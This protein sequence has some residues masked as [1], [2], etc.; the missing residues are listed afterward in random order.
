[1]KKVY[2]SLFLH[3]NMCYDRYTKQ[4]IRAKFPLIYAAGIRA[5]QRYPQVTA[6]IDFPGLTTLSLKHHAAWF[7]QELRS[8]VERGQVVMVG[9]QYAASHAMCSDE[10][11]DLQA[12]RLGMEIMRDELQP[13]VS[14]FFNQEIPFHPQEPYIM[15]QIGARRLLS[16]VDWGRPTWI[17][18]IDGSRLIICPLSSRRREGVG[19]LEGIY[20]LYEDGDL[21]LMGGDFEMLGNVGEMV[22]KIAELFARG[23]V[24]EWMTIDR[25]ERELGAGEE[26][27]APTPF[28][29]SPEDTP[30]SPSFSRWV[31]NPEDAIWHGHGVRAMDAIRTAGFAA[32]CARVHGLGAVDAPLSEAWTTEPDNAW[33]G[34]FEH[35]LEYPEVEARYLAW[36]RHPGQGDGH[37]TLLSRAWHHLLIGLNSDASGWKPWQPRTRHRETVLRASEALSKEV[38]ERFA[39]QLAAR[40]EPAR[41]GASAH[42]LAINPL[43]AR[44]VEISLATEEPMA[45]VEPDGTPIATSTLFQAGRW[46]VG[47]RVTLPAY[48][49]KLFGLVPTSQISRY[50]W[51]PGDRVRTGELASALSEG[52]LTISRGRDNLEVS[53]SPFNL[54]D[55]SGVAE[56][57]AVSPHWRDAQTRVR[58]TWQ[59]PELEILAELAWTVWLRL[60][61]GLRADHVELAAEVYVDMPRRI[62]RVRYDAEGHPLPFEAQGADES[63]QQ[64]T[65]RFDPDGLRLALRGQA[66]R[67]Y[68]DIPYSTIQQPNERASFVAAQRFVALESEALSFGL[69]S[70]GGNQSF[71]LAAEEGLI[72]AAM[73]A[74]TQGRPDTRPEC[75]IRPDGTA[76]HHITSCGDPFMGRYGH[77]FALIFGGRDELALAARRLR[78]AVHLARVQPGGGSWPAQGSLLTI[79]PETAYVT[80]FRVSPE[81]CQLVVNDLS[82]QAGEV[83]WR[84]PAGRTAQRT[85]LAAYGVATL[86]I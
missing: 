79:A 43:P 85:P 42:V 68:Y 65:W 75:V 19:G 50:T 69:V 74:S 77:R 48:G 56:T 45:L 44:A 47:A 70:L 84:A 17:K 82:G 24:I 1:M 29:P 73:G 60:V 52:R 25:Y 39:R 78:T 22:A 10:E 26:V 8:L 13:D 55:P 46:S 38:V 37:P 51:L 66:G 31:S 18:G 61:I 57:Q 7:L 34:L 80:A 54:S 53:V 14:T 28:R 72:A 49:Y 64:V 15:G 2:L 21:V 35:V 23:K 63:H 86:T 71:E 30:A 58:E 59:G 6:H 4:E 41:D 36:D 27:A 20:D 40:L 76:E 11:S 33:D 5:M 12:G 67:A 9:C 3:G 81:G 62:G 32:V 16:G 83:A